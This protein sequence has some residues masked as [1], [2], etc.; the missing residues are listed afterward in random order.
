MCDWTIL[1]LQFNKWSQFDAVHIFLY[2]AQGRGADQLAFLATS[3]A[4]LL[5]KKQE[6]CLLR[7]G[8]HQDHVTEL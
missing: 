2:L 5:C 6:R 1:L 4:C 7:V 8:K 3:Q